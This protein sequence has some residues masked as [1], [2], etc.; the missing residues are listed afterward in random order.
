MQF[1]V[2][3]KKD[4]THTFR[5]AVHNKQ[6]TA[7]MQVVQMSE[8]SA[9]CGPCPSLT[10]DHENNRLLHVTIFIIPLKQSSGACMT[11]G[12]KSLCC[13]T[14]EVFKSLSN[15]TSEV[16]KSLCSVTSEV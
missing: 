1:F 8:Q 5:F 12:C 4:A 3:V 2:T 11:A 14:S 16:C 13:V 9:R 7:E 10:L 6:V 15:V